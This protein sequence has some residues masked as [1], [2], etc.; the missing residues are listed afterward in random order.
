M[1]VSLS[2]T[3]L[4]LTQWSH[5]VIDHDSGRDARLETAFPGGGKSTGLFLISV[6]DLFL[7]A[8]KYLP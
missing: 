5:I 2:P 1:Y 8:F 7:F 4:S 3:V 6:F